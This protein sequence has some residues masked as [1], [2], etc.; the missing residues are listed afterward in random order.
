MDH[1]D[2]CA[3][4]AEIR[5]LGLGKLWNMYVDLFSKLNN[6]AQGYLEDSSGHLAVWGSR[7]ARCGSLVWLRTCAQFSDQEL[8][9]LRLSHQDTWLWKYGSFY[10]V[11]IKDKT[12]IKNI[13]HFFTQ[14]QQTLVFVGYVL[15]SFSD[16]IHMI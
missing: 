7:W 12:K 16:F 3:F 5:F 9:A 4:T 10:Q 15:Y 2:D 1:T 6:A 8:V 14:P 13:W 11:S